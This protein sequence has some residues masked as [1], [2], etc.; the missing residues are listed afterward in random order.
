[1]IFKQIDFVG[2]FE[3][4]NQCPTLSIPEFAFI[5]RSNVGKSSLI[6]CIT[7]RKE[8]ARVSKKPGKTQHMNFFK[9]NNSWHLVDL[10]GYGYAQTSKKNRAKWGIMIESYLAKR[11]QL[12]CAFNLIDLNIPPQKIDLEFID[13]M[14]ANRVPFVLTFTKTD[15]L[16]DREISERV[17]HYLETLSKS[18][19]SMP[20]HFITSSTKRIGIESIHEFM[21][22][23]VEKTSE[24]HGKKR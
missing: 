20:Q 1:M 18:W 12:I 6:N 13:W 15:R 10:P 8:L 17:D 7:G 24:R 3:K 2:S 16:K 19:N 5:G 23:F 21:G 14:G 22:G 11:Q 9:I 4:D